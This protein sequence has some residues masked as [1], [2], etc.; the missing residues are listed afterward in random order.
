MFINLLI[1]TTYFPNVDYNIQDNRSF[2]FF[3]VGYSVQSSPFNEAWLKIS[4][5]FKMERQ[6]VE[7][8]NLSH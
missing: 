1:S 8:A 2:I 7:E 4:V 5:I 3:D 6:D